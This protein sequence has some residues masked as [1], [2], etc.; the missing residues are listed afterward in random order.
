LAE[1]HSTSKI[2]NAGGWKGVH[3]LN[4]IALGQGPASFADLVTQ[5]F[6]WSRSLL[7]ILLQYTPRYFSGLTGRQKF[8]FV[9]SQLWYPLFAVFMAV[10]FALPIVA[11]CFDVTLAQVS[12]PGFV[13]HS[14][15]ATLVLITLAY[16][17]RAD[18]LFRPVDAKV[19]GWEKA[20][21]AALQWPWVLW[22]CTMALRDRFFGGFV[23]F[24]VT[25][26]GGGPV[27]MLP[28]LVLWPY[29]ALAIGSILPVLLVDGVKTASGFYFFALLNALLY[30]SLF[31]VIVINHCRENALELRS[32]IAGLTLQSCCVAALSAGIFV[33]VQTRGEA[34]L[35]A[36]ATT[37]SDVSFIVPHS[38]I[39]GAGRGAAQD[40]QYVY[41]PRWVAELFHQS[42]H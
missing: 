32:N 16:M 20:F 41:N 17:I 12:F 39:A 15:P 26:K 24:R 42:L 25:P 4:A 27:S 19:L 36:L 23:D 2:L 5:E 3:A 10:M 14:L 1:D 37:Q 38:I 13:L 21:F 34:A 6:Q 30:V 35:I 31:V 22:G 33:A 18:G 8:Q 9:F 11:I 7:T 40:V 29:L 28:W